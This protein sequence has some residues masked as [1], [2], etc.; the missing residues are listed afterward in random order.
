M[1]STEL[2]YNCLE[3]A[4]RIKPGTGDITTEAQVFL[5]F[6]EGAYKRHKSTGEMVM[7]DRSLANRIA[8]E[9]DDMVYDPVRDAYF[10][11]KEIASR[12]D[13]EIEPT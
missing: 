3:L 12:A 9:R 11:A 6:V 2:R 10:S 1:E 13:S 4:H 8:S 7:V 5:D